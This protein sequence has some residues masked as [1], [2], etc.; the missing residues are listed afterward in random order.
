MIIF[1]QCIKKSKKINKNNCKVDIVRRLYFPIVL[2]C[3]INK[4]NG[5]KI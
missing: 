5:S 2:I 4:E 3:K 1:V